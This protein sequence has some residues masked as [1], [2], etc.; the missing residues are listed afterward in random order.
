M[1]VCVRAA[2]PLPSLTS[3]V[4]IRLGRARPP[5]SSSLPSFESPLCFSLACCSAPV[6]Q[7]PALSSPEGKRPHEP[8][9]RVCHAELLR[10][11]TLLQELSPQ[12]RCLC[13]R[14]CCSARD[15]GG[16]ASP[17]R[18]ATGS[19]LCGGEVRMRLAPCPS[20]PPSPLQTLRLSRSQTASLPNLFLPPP[21]SASRPDYTL[22]TRSS[23][24]GV[25]GSTRLHFSLL[26]HV[27][28]FSY[29]CY[30]FLFVFFPCARRRTCRCNRL[31]I[32]CVPKHE[33]PQTR[34]TRVHILPRA[35]G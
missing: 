11:H 23:T 22:R 13:V 25:G 2:P 17:L 20:L 35:L 5:P 30:L 8:G 21:P 3:A 6:C 28:L 29:L 10:R 34:A 12:R 26:S 4:G 7:R 31:P 14:A 33:K 9:E 32:M 18:R 15:C 1:C 24:E 16:S 27:S 19:V